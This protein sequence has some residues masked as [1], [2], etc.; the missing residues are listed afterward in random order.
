M[1]RVHRLPVVVAVEEDGRLRP[2]G[3]QL[4]EHHRAAAVGGEDFRADAASLH[5]LLERFGVAHDVGHVGGVVGQPEE[6]HQLVHNLG[7]V[8]LAIGA[9]TGQGFRRRVGSF[10]RK[11]CRRKNQHKGE[12]R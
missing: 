7:G 5:H 10:A 9:H 2:G 4:A 1:V 6:R 12:P 3:S 8:R 11:G